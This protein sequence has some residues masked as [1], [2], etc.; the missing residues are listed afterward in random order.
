MIARK[1]KKEDQSG[2]AA[3]LKRLLEL[4]Q[5]ND[6]DGGEGDNSCDHNIT[7][8]PDAEGLF[9]LNLMQ[10]MNLR[11]LIDTMIGIVQFAHI[12]HY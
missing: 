6:G 12:I 11:V 2:S 1:A 3:Q 5:D 7:M 9:P 4:E 8:V 10:K